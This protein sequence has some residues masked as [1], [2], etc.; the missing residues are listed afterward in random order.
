MYAI[1]G[2]LMYKEMLN[3]LIS[4]KKENHIAY[5]R[6]FKYTFPKIQ[7]RT[8]NEGTV[9]LNALVLSLNINVHIYLFILKSVLSF[10]LHK[11]LQTC[12]FSFVIDNFIQLDERR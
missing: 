5:G 9:L 7:F 6:K 12:I 2:L 1:V 4:R 11:C 8:M 3:E 10:Y